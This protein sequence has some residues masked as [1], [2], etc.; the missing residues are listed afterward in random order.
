M[1]LSR[2]LINEE[3]PVAQAPAGRTAIPNRQPAE[4]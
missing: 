2:A 4:P 3:E 1:D